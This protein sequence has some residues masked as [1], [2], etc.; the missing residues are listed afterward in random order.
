MAA[1]IV[2][3]ELDVSYSLEAVEVLNRKTERGR[4]YLTITPHGYVPALEL[5][6]G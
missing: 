3:E 1:H 4:D 6:N 5:D 2:L